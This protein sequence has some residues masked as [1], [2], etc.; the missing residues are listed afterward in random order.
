MEHHASYLAT[1]LTN[2]LGLE[3]HD[4]GAFAHGQ[5]LSVLERYD[6]LFA[7]VLA[8]L[9]TIL[10]V[11]LVRLRMTKVP[12]PYQ[13][14]MEYAVTF[15]RNLV[16]EN[17]EHHPEKYVPLVGTMG[18]FVLL[19]NLFGLA[20]LPSGTGNWNVTLACALVVFCYYNWQG[21]REHG[22]IKY[23]AHFLGPVWW[24]APLMFPLE[25][26]GLVSRILSHSLRLFGNVAGEHVVAGIFFGMLPFLLPVPLMFLGI[27]FGMIQAFVFI[28]LT[29][30][31]ISGAVAHEH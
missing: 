11:F 31:Y 12:R 5:P 7:A 24:L 25:I 6:H 10:L 13:Q 30:I 8:A 2:W 18:F 14:V 9:T 22:F 19:N 17:V 15:V 16:G 21:M 23:W 29:A 26:L 28:M 20:P 27:F 4:W 3:R 1:L